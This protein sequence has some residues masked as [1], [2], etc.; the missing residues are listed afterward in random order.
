MSTL[1]PLA[2]RAPVNVDIEFTRSLSVF[3]VGGS[4]VQL[5]LSVKLSVY[6]GPVARVVSLPPDV[7]PS[8]GQ[9]RFVDCS[10]ELP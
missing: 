1:R 8:S 9:V 2:T 7:Q 4:L 6:A 5:A 3:D 10:G